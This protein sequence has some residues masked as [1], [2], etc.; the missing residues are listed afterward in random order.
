MAGRFKR[1]DFR[2]AVEEIDALPAA[3]RARIEAGASDIVAAQRLSEVRRLMKMTQ[4]KLSAATDI[5]QGEI[6]RIERNP[7]RVQLQT[8]GRYVEGL[9]G[10]LRLVAVFPDGVRAEMPIL[11]RQTPRGRSAAGDEG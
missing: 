6:S 3:R 5:K 9:G 8:L 1:S 7:G 11:G 2:S 10:E 4:Q